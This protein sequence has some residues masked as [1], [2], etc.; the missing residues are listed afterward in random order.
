[1]ATSRRDFFISF[2]GADLAYAEAIDKALKEAGFTTYF[3]PVDLAAG[4]NILIWMDVALDNSAQTLALYS[5]AYTSDT[6]VYS[7]AERYA[8]LWQDPVSDKRKLIPVL[9]KDTTFT[10][11]M[12][13]IKYIDVRGKMQADAAAYVVQQLNT[14]AEQVQRDIWRRGVPLPKIFR[15]AYR[16]NHNFTGRFEDL[17]SLQQ[18]LR[19]GTNAAI[20]AVAGMGG[21]GKTTLAAEY[22]H[23]FGGR[24]G[25][26]WLV[27]AEQ[28]STMLGDLQVLGQKL[29]IVDGKNTEADAR[30]TLD[31]LA[32]LSEPWLLVYDNAP[33][34]DAV[35]KWLPLGAVRCIIT[36]RF[37]DFGD[38]APVTRLDKWPEDVTAEYLLKR[39]GRDDKEGAARLAHTLGGLPL[40]AEQAAAYLTN[41]NGISFDDY[42]AEIA[43]LIK[44]PRPA[45]AKG[46]YPDTV[47]AAFVKSLEELG[48]MKGGTTALDILRLCS[49]LSPDGV[50][51]FL[52]TVKW[53]EK[54]FPENFAAAMKDK[55]A[56]ADALAA[57]TS[58]SLMR[59]E[60]DP[61]GQVLVFHRLLLEV[62]RDWMGDDVRVMWGTAAVRLINGNFPFDPDNCPSAWPICERL[63]RHL[64]TLEANILPSGVAGKA[65]DRLLNQ[66]GIYLSARGDKNGA[67]ALMER[68][69]NLQRNTR[70]DEPLQLAAGLA[71]LAGS[72]FEVGRL[73]D[74]ESLYQ[75]ALSIMEP[76]LGP[77]DADL[78]VTFLNLARVYWK[79]RKFG[80]AEPL[81]TRYLEVMKAAYGQNS[82][83]YGLGLSSL[84]ALYGDWADE[85]SE[86]G[87]WVQALDF[88]AR[89]LFVTLAARSTRHP[90]TVVR[91]ANLA[92]MNA[93]T[94]NWP[95]AATD[96]ERAIAIRLSLDLAGHGEM[97]DFLADLAKF[98][99]RSRQDAKLAR[100]MNGDLTVFHPIVEQI[101]SEHRAWVAADPKNRKFGPPSPITGATE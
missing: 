23:R 73:D 56:R 62:V 4:G 38:V 65:L 35:R 36:S 27:R 53:G 77:T 82:P 98:W 48:A 3:H 25:G 97:P 75:E 1:M 78:A 70:S 11:L 13:P 74:A 12:A 76:Q 40:A 96:M 49:F 95:D 71:N 58:L 46:D 19:A 45:G 51:E 7:K 85:P 26:V 90:Q 10:P 101:E 15:A 22:C 94:K 52:L 68:C 100:L 17:E 16:P 37:T 42:G 64:V 14:G 9:L 8:T 79:Q 69:V 33:N 60:E 99:E 20:T 93:K 59:S 88:S 67:L 44:E 30:A 47:Y 6:A 31:Y 86:E 18:S 87:R 61:Y 24:Y 28:E 39:T 89:A 57:L 29:E 21:I 66:C 50:G 91:Y 34:P 80:K 63:T 54:V 92:H 81:A 32:N 2:N 84:G 55:L 72:Y 43:R 83:Q 5:P 41:R